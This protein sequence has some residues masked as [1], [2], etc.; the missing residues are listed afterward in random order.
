MGAGPS[1][2]SRLR[3]RE[4]KLLEGKERGGGEWAPFEASRRCVEEHRSDLRIEEDE[5]GGGRGGEGLRVLEILRRISNF[6][7][8]EAI[9]FA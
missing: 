5:E 8:D 9:F 4:H 6:E 2:P 3:G 1:S 7:D